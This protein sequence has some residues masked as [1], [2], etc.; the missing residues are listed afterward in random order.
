MQLNQAEKNILQLLAK[1]AVQR[2]I[3]EPETTSRSKPEKS[4]QSVN[5]QVD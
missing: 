3:T 5:K 4:K 1:Q 2:I